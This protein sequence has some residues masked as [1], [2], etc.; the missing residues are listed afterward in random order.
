MADEKNKSP[1]AGERRPDRAIPLL[2]SEILDLLLAAANFDAA[3]RE[4][5]R[6]L[7]RLLG[8][9]FHY[10]YL[11]ERERLREAYAY[12]N[13]DRAPPSH[14]DEAR[15]EAAYAALM[16]DFVGV[17][18]RANFIEVTR[19]EIE[20]A[21]AERA[22]VRVKIK[23]RLDQ[24]RAVRIFRRGRHR[25]TIEQPAW[26]GL[27]QRPV[28]IE[29]FDDVV[30]MVATKP[31]AAANAAGR[32]SKRRHGRDI[33]PGAV[34]FKSFRHVAS[35]DINALFPNVRV[36]M[37]LI[38]QLKLG[39]PA[40]VGGVPL[41]IKFAS[42]VTVLF[43]VLGAYFGVSGTLG[44]D[45]LK[46][47][48]AALSGVVALGG[49]MLR[50]WGNFHRQALKHE[51]QLTDNI[52]YRNLNNNAGLFDV[53]IGEAEEQEWKEALLAYGVIVAAPAGLSRAEV[54]AR[55]EAMLTRAGAKAVDFEIDDAL[56][57]LARLGLL[58][59]DAGR[60]TAPPLADALGKLD[61]VWDDYFSA[62]GADRRRL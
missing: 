11:D 53:L 22:M 5:L 52:Y 31:P 50:Q 37:S 25:E 36:V 34:M 12:F 4:R 54:D 56:D 29:V 42:T 13:P 7:A 20:R 33:R 15:I 28:E 23:A 55:I 40:I 6:R 17:L 47:A 32:R 14:L 60:L 61:A 43:L 58:I 39:V 10:E 51:K 59:E 45:D 30:L 41:L 3:D 46:Q 35:A 21:F 27:R 62:A 49:F 1:V 48:L 24:F 38:D 8:A 16:Q 9:V 26:F 18:T 44:D 19:A 57:K 2:K